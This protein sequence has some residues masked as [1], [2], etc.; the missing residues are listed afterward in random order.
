MD[1]LMLDVSDIENVYEGTEV[2][3]FG[4]DGDEFISVDDLAKI[5]GKINYEVVC[6]IGKRVP[7]IFLK[8]G[9]IIG[10]VSYI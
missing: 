5:M 3:V 6:L 2:T 9:E 4:H 7:R 10:K 8:N 1:Q